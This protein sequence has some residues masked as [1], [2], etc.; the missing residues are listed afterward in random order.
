MLDK[1]KGLTRLKHKRFN[2]DTI[3]VDV[4]QNKRFNKIKTQLI[5]MLDKTKGLTR[6][7]HN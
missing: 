4:R 2:I 7:K 5:L 3:D 1:T 6:L